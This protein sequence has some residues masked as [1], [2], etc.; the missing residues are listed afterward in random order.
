M[1]QMQRG[2]KALMGLELG[3]EAVAR[4][5]SPA[6][7]SSWRGTVSRQFLRVLLVVVCALGLTAAI[8]ARA[9]KAHAAPAV[10][11]CSS[12][13]EVLKNY[14]AWSYDSTPFGTLIEGAWIYGLYDNTN[15]A[16]CGATG[17]VQVDISQC[18]NICS[19]KMTWESGTKWSSAGGTFYTSQCYY[20]YTRSARMAVIPSGY[21]YKTYIYSED[22]LDPG[23]WTQW[24]R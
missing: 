15:D 21:C 2:M 23:A 11:Q 22:F 10:T 17:V 19:V 1:M 16:F 14:D 20:Y 9:P 3:V 5:L 12:V 4:R 7:H 13:Y 24:C 18:C 6:A 8:A